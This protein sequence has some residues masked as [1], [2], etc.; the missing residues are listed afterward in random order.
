MERVD[1]EFERREPLRSAR[2]TP[3]VGAGRGIDVAALTKAFHRG[4]TTIEALRGLDFRSASGSF[5]SLVGPSGCGKST[6]LRVL[7]GLETPTSGSVLLSGESPDKV[8]RAGRLSL[9][10]QDSALLPW[11]TV[12]A[13]VALPLEITRARAAADAVDRLLGVVGLAGFEDARPRQLSGGMR[14]RVAIAQALVTEPRFLFLD[15]PFGALDDISR[16]R[17]N[18]EL[19]GALASMDTTSVLVTHS[20]TEAV[21]VADEVVLMSPRP[22]R[23]VGTLSVDLPRPR[24]PE[25][26]K[27]QAFHELTDQVASVLFKHADDV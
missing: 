11:R 15:E 1:D 27:S 24:R 19:M 17:L 5:T 6:L 16:R 2:S 22:G 20:I 3:R 21:F 14:Q 13:N 26:L 23:V 4:R 18:S 7:A 8:R 25:M 10:F 12:R 9:V